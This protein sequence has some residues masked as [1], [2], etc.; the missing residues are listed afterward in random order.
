MRQLAAKRK[1]LFSKEYLFCEN[2]LMQD[3]DVAIHEKPEKCPICGSK[4]YKDDISREC[5]VVRNFILLPIL[6]LTGSSNVLNLT[7]ICHNL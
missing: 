7:L 2:C 5:L 1:A 4:K 6:L 3:H